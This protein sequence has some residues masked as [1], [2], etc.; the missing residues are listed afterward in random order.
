MKAAVVTDAGPVREW[1]RGGAKRCAQQG[2]G[3]RQTG[4]A[5]GQLA[6]A[7]RALDS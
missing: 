1:V 3:K 5:P 4:D 7:Q 6:G 2:Q